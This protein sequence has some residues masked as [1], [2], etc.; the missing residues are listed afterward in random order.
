MIS[1]YSD[2]GKKRERKTQ[3]V[4]RYK[5]K[6]QC[7]YKLQYLLDSQWKSRSYKMKKS[8]FYFSEH[9]PIGKISINKLLFLNITI[10]AGDNSNSSHHKFFL[11]IC[12]LYRDEWTNQHHHHH[13]WQMVMS[14][15]IRLPE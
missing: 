12:I 8:A 13:H 9:R 11:G 7:C 14:N 2:E 6:V 1:Y 3:S 10:F 5:R 15:G 4:E